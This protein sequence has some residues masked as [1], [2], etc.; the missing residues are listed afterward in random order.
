[1][2]QE[3]VVRGT[4]G[5]RVEGAPDWV[6]AGREVWPRVGDTRRPLPEDAPYLCG[7]LYAVSCCTRDRL[8]VREAT[9]LGLD[10]T[11]SDAALAVDADLD[12]DGVPDVVVGGGTVRRQYPGNPRDCPTGLAAAVSGRTGATLW[13]LPTPLLPGAPDAFS[14]VPAQPG[15]DFEY[16]WVR[17]VAA[18]S[19]DVSGDGVPDVLLFSLGDT[20]QTR[21]VLVLSGRD[22]RPLAELAI[23]QPP[24]E[25][26]LP[27]HRT[28][29]V[30]TRAVAR[31]A[32]DLDGDGGPEWVYTCQ[33][34]SGEGLAAVGDR[35]IEALSLTGG[36][37]LWRQALDRWGSD[38]GFGA[39]SVLGDVDGDGHP[40][41]AVPVRFPRNKRDADEGGFRWHIEIRRGLDGALLHTLEPPPGETFG[42]W[43]VSLATAPG[44]PVRLAV[45]ADLTDVEWRWEAFRDPDDPPPRWS[46][47]Y[48]AVHFYQQCPAEGG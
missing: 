6:V 46:E 15:D 29:Y 42:P 22:G 4:T 38:R 10:L 37:V 2:E 26:P 7:R 23:A 47:P 20:W 19:P 24:P 16:P 14:G 45:P 32:V 21:G 3:F 9:D 39:V 13:A 34:Y 35:R 30:F 12:G 31:F 18:T 40:D 36:G 48:G 8:W 41:L 25:Q 1:M 44:A 27:G 28:T 11:E 5:R 17:T 33:V 43:P